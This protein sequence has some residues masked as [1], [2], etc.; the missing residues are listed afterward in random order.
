MHTFLG[1]FHQGGKYSARIASHQSELIKEDNFTDNKSLSI[2]YLQA[3]YLN[4]EKS[5]GCCRNSERAN[6]VHTN[7]T[8]CGGANHSAENCFKKIRKENEKVHAAGDLNKRQQNV[9]VGKL[10]IVDLKII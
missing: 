7:C 5:S 4:L 9:R 6:T 8:S 10:F 1:N 2:S 3:D